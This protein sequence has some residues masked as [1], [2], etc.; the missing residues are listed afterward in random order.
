MST[1]EEYSDK[2]KFLDRQSSR[3]NNQTTTVCSDKNQ[4]QN[5]SVLEK[6][7]EISGGQMLAN[8]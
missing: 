2:G 6:K 8:F 3:V 5:I 7:N 4:S 1:N